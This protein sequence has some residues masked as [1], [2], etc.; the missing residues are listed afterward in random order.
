MMPQNSTE[1][2]ASPGNSRSPRSILSGIFAFTPNRDTLGGTSYFIVDNIGNIL[3]DC[4]AVNEV[5]Q[6]FIRSQGGIDYFIISHRGGIGKHVQQLQQAFNCQ[7]II[8]EQEAYLLP[9]CEVT[10][11]ADNYALNAELELIWGEKP[12]V[13]GFENHGGRTYLDTVQPLGKTIAGYG[14][15]GED[16]MEGAFHHNAIATYSHGP[17]L[18]KNPFIT[19]WLIKKALQKKYQEEIILSKLDDSL[20]IAARK[21]ML[22][23]LDLLNIVATN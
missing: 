11:F 18:A 13:I 14:N 4:P 20:A 6:E 3:I 9:E 5:N 7:V 1:I 16:G 12:I 23:R 21:A 15:N 8:Q 10:S 2:T 22:Q 17:L 19:D